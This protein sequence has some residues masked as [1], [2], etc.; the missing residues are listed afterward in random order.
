MNIVLIA[1][2]AVCQLPSLI[3]IRRSGGA[4]DFISWGDHGVNFG[5]CNCDCEKGKGSVQL[6]AVQ[7]IV[8]VP[9]IKIHDFGKKQDWDIDGK[10]DN[11]DLSKQELGKQYTFQTQKMEQSD[12]SQ[13]EVAGKY[14][15]DKEDWQ[16][17]DKKLGF[18]F[19]FA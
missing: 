11:L 18:D 13:W 1:L 19:S 5:G 2:F 12:E 15:F 8:K 7:K 14:D 17:G 10:I 3:A 6:M 16:F 9:K 4:F